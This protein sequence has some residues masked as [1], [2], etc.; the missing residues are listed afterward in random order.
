MR[1]RPGRGALSAVIVFVTT[2]L[3]HAAPPRITERQELPTRESTEENLEK[4]SEPAA[5]REPRSLREWRAARG[6]ESERGTEEPAESSSPPAPWQPL[7]LTVVVLG[8]F[9]VGARWLQRTLGARGVGGSRVLEIVART[10]LTTK[11]QAVLL[12]VGGRAILVGVTGERVSR[13]GEWSE[14][15]EVVALARD[16]QFAQQLRDEE[17]SYF[18]EDDAAES[19]VAARANRNGAESDSRIASFRR[20]LSPFPNG[21]NGRNDSRGSNGS[22]GDRE[23]NGGTA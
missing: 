1:F 7:V 19:Q 9:L 21:A 8:V 4:K 2:V 22:S 17:E 14:P 10:P 3:A 5:E 12:K 23:R 15:S 13:L 16:G 20:H 11:S 6:V 18:A